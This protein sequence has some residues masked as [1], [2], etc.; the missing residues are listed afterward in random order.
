MFFYEVN[1]YDEE[2]ACD[3]VEQG[4]CRGRNWVEAQNSVID[5]YGSESVNW[6]RIEISAYDDVIPMHESMVQ[7]IK[8]SQIW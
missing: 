2:S 5:Y 4:V 8:E 7:E 1:Y 3:N 6:I